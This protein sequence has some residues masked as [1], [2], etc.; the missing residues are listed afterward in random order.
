MLTCRSLV[1]FRLGLEK[2]FK[3]LAYLIVNLVKDL[4]LV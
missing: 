4:I 1:N 2:F 3:P